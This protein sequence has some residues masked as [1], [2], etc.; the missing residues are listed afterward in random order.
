MHYWLKGDGRLCVYVRLCIFTI[1]GCVYT[2]TRT[3]TH[4]YTHTYTHTTFDMCTGTGSLTVL[5]RTM[6]GNSCVDSQPSRG[7]SMNHQATTKTQAIKTNSFPGSSSS[8]VILL[9]HEVN[10]F[11]KSSANTDDGQEDPNDC[12]AAENS[13]RNLSNMNALPPADKPEA[14]HACAIRYDATSSGNGIG[15]EFQ[16]VYNRCLDTSCQHN[17]KTI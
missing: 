3:H 13:L 12:L 7:K 9:D 11:N 2:H 8:A 17:F 6:S 4:T 5:R 1:C 15:V 14:L 16:I 10:E